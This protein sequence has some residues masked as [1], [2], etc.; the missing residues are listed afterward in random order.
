MCRHVVWFLS[1]DRKLVKELRGVGK[2]YG[3]GSLLAEVPY[4]ID[5]YQEFPSGIPGYKEIVGRLAVSPSIVFPVG[6]E[7]T[8]ELA[9]GTRFE[10]YFRNS[11]GDIAYKSGMRD[12]SGKPCSI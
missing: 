5:V 9:D 11:G 2:V 8:L 12:A 4:A 10:F 7:L 6:D 1:M 3:K